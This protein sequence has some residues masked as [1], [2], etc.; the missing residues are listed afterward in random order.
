LRLVR[1]DAMK[2]ALFRVGQL[3]PVPFATAGY[4]VWITKLIA[5]S[6]RICVKFPELRN[7]AVKHVV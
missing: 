4:L 6:R 5:F 2:P 3:A 7:Y 1:G